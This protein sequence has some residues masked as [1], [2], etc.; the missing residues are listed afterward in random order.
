M[1]EA[2]FA[3]PA[4][5]AESAISNGGDMAPPQPSA[6]WYWQTDSR[7]RITHLFGSPVARS[8][9]GKRPWEV[10]GVDTSHP[11]WATVFD[12]FM[13]RKPFQNAVWR[14]RDA[15][16]RVHHCLISGEPMFGPKGR[17]V[18]FRGVGRDLAV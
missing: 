18:G 7:Y 4:C 1:P 6:G 17:F 11:G 13:A 12:A 2:L 14:R 5:A 9:L 3:E 8:A 15:E 10:I 16:G